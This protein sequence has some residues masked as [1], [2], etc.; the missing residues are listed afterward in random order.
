M[1]EHIAGWDIGGAHVKAALINSQGQVVQVLQQ[2][3]PL[4][5]GI[6]HLQQCISELLVAFKVQPSVHAL[7]MTG[8]LADC[9]ISREQGVQTIIATLTQQIAA[10]KLFI[11]ASHCGFLPVFSV[12]PEH[13]LA[14]AS[15]TWLASASLVAK[16]SAQGLFVDIGSTTTDIL[17]IKDHQL[18][19]IGH[20]DYQRLVSGELLYTGVVRTSIMA[21]CQN[22]V[23][24]CQSMGLMAEHFATLADVYRLTSDLSAGHDQAETADGGDKTPLA[25]ARRLSRLTG[26][27]FSVDDWSDWLDFANFLKRL[28]KEKIWQACQRQLQS[29]HSKTETVIIGAGIGR[30]LLKELAAERGLHYQD[31]NDFIAPNFN[32]SD[33]QP[34]DCAPAVAV[35]YL[36][37]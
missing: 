15:V 3:C 22:A 36:L 26:Y 28:H 13:T 16:K 37:L 19:I 17:S 32:S 6:T 8:E 25:S 9:F 35:A 2:A 30:F 5:K 34:A 20:T 1:S 29:Q 10:E 21:L 7:T 14:I 33:L 23:F 27:E 12:K 4:W 31:F 18:Q 24:K 11:Y